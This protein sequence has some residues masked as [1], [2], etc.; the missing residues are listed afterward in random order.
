MSKYHVGDG[1]SS[2][3]RCRTGIPT[4][5]RSLF[6]PMQISTRMSTRWKSGIR[7]ISMGCK[8]VMMR[9]VLWLFSWWRQD[10]IVL[11]ENEKKN[12]I[13]TTHSFSN[14][15]TTSVLCETLCFFCRCNKR[16]DSH[17]NKLWWQM[18]KICKVQLFICL[19]NASEDDPIHCSLSTR[20][21]TVSREWIC[22][23]WVIEHNKCLFALFFCIC[24][25]TNLHIE[26]W[27]TKYSKN[28]HQ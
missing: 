1:I 17:G 13:T 3:N 21:P 16:N 10:W 12:W 9:C 20:Y 8:D 4:C 18:I 14:A 7:E 5:D 6:A 28:G 2:L 26:I 27:R 15:T 25:E 22:I 23:N 24:S 19:P 11:R